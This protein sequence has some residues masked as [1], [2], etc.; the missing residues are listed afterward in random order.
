MTHSPAVERWEVRWWRRWRWG[1]RCSCRMQRCWWSGGWQCR[2]VRED[3]RGS[4]PARSVLRPDTLQVST[5]PPVH[6]HLLSP[7]VNQSVL[8]SPRFPLGG[9]QTLQVG[10]IHIVPRWYSASSLTQLRPDWLSWNATKSWWISLCWSCKAQAGQTQGESNF[11]L[12][13]Q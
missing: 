8:T 6:Q 1:W 3:W 4:V 7:S 5:A 13:P 11:R 9:Q 2:E 12:R 10:L